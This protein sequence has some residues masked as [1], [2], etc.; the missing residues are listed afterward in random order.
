MAMPTKR[1]QRKAGLTLTHASEFA[2]QK[3]K[4]LACK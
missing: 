2:L 4:F 1:L 3:I